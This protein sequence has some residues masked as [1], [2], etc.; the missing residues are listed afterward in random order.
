LDYNNTI[1]TRRCN[2]L[3]GATGL[4]NF[5]FVYLGCRTQSKVKALIRTCAVDS[6]T[7]PVGASAKAIRRNKRFRANGVTW[8]F[9]FSNK[10]LLATLRSTVG[11]GI[12]VV[13]HNIGMTIVEKITKSRAECSNYV[14][15]AAA[16]CGRNLVKFAPVQIPK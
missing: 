10:L 4:K 5:D 9:P 14:S 15:Q 6:S 1:Y 8:T 3:L 11:H 2:L 13:D 12:N 16:S 7:K